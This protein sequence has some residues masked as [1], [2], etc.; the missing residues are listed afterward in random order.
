[1]SFTPAQEPG[2][3]YTTVILFAVELANFTAKAPIVG[4]NALDP[5]T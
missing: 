2:L 3:V 1:M 5:S 4:T